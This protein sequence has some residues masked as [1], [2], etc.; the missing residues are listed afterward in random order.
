MLLE[1]A[2][3][4]AMARRRQHV[5]IRDSAK[6]TAGTLGLYLERQASIQGYYSGVLNVE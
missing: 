6:Q 5:Q 4:A 2:L 3:T 1:A